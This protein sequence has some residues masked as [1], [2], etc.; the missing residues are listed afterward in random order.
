[1][2]YNVKVASGPWSLAS[3]FSVQVSGVRFLEFREQKADGH[4]EDE[5]P[6]M[7]SFFYLPASFG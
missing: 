3:G 7:N 4:T 6:Y 1:M 2:Y 5:K